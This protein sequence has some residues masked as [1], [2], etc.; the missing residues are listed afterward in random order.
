MC[1]ADG[2]GYLRLHHSLFET[3]SRASTFVEIIDFGAYA[4]TNF[5]ISKNMTSTTNYEPDSICSVSRHFLVGDA[6]A[7]FTCTTGGDS[8]DGMTSEE[9]CIESGG[10]WYSYNCNGK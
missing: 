8:N 6:I 4:E 9:T 7:G 2:Q 5:T 10:T 1:C 3:S